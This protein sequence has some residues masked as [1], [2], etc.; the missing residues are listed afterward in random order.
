MSRYYAAH[1]RG[2]DPRH[3]AEAHSRPAPRRRYDPVAM[4]GGF[5]FAVA[6]AATIILCVRDA[7][8]V[9]GFLFMVSHGVGI[10]AVIA[11]VP[12]GILLGLLWCGFRYADRSNH[13]HAP[14]MFAG[15]AV[16]LLLVNEAPWPGTQANRSRR[17]H[18]FD[19]IEVRS[20]HDDDLLSAR[21]N[22]IGIRVTYEVYSP[23]RVVAFTYL[24]LNLDWSLREG[25][26]LL[27]LGEFWG[28]ADTIEPESSKGI[29]KV[30]EG[31]AIY[32]LTANRMPGFLAY[33]EKTQQPCFRSRSSS[34]YSETDL[35]SAINATGRRKYGMT[36]SFSNDNAS[37]G[38]YA[39]YMT[40]REYDLSE[41]YQTI[42]KEGYPRCGF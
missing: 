32:R 41:M 9:I 37:I 35:V 29:Y 20:I 33:D 21:G 3:I 38:H 12:L 11:F 42:V 34:K 25:G 36:I 13:R 22:P 24:R 19:A 28:P 5:A 10:V 15:F 30:L 18:T 39:S 8:V 26:P 6:L 1:S 4:K 16:A 40:S 17:Q 14:L 31:G 7:S 27:D 23:H 2:C